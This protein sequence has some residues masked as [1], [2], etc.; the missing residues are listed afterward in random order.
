MELAFLAKDLSMLRPLAIC[1]GY[2]PTMHAVVR[3]CRL[4]YNYQQ[5]VRFDVALKPLVFVGSTHRGVT[6]QTRPINLSL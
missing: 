5:V 6:S 2:H 4:V 1:L 3:Y